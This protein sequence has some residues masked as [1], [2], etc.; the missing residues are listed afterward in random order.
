MRWMRIA[1]FQIRQ[2]VKVPYFIQLMAISTVTTVIVQFL[3]WQAWSVVQPEQAWI[4]AGIIGLWTTC[5]AAAGIIGF[6]RFKGT[7]VHLVLAPIGSLRVSAGVVGAASIFGLVAFPLSWLSWALLSQSASFDFATWSRLGWVTLGILL[8]WLGS[9]AM[10][11]VVSALFFLTPN[12]ITYEGLLLTPIFV[13]SG[14]MFTTSAIPRPIY[15][16]SHIFPLSWPID[17]LFGRAE[18]LDFLQF[19]LWCLC[20]IG[21]ILVAWAAGRF[22][23]NKATR[24]G[25]LEVI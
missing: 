9:V 14:V 20:F 10:S 11:L 13:F 19:L 6:E 3:A 2:F 17:L 16:L 8:L 7:L 15:V 4:R 21:W 5:T 22:A 23:L 1:A 18:A 24:A 12:A 25:T